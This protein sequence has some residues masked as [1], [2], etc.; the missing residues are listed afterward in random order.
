[1]RNRDPTDRGSVPRTSRARIRLMK[2]CQSG[3]R[4]SPQLRLL[5]QLPDWAANTRDEM[6]SEK[7][8][9]IVKERHTTTSRVDAHMILLREVFQLEGVDRHG[10]RT[11]FLGLGSIKHENLTFATLPM[12]LFALRTATHLVNQH[13]HAATLTPHDHMRAEVLWCVEVTTSREQ[14]SIPKD[15][16]RNGWCIKVK[17]Q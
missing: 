14:E 8:A 13:L 2:T 12:C 15:R 10:K 6:V 7:R 17:N 1:M 4:G 16:Q 9:A 3:P 5:Q 11:A